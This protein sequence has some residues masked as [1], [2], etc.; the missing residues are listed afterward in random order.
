[1]ALTNTDTWSPS[2]NPASLTES[3]AMTKVISSLPM[4]AVTWDMISPNLISVTVPRYLFLTPAFTLSPPKYFYLFTANLYMDGS[5]LLFRSVA[6]SFPPLLFSHR[7][8]SIGSRLEAL[9]AGSSPKKCRDH[10]PTSGLRAAR[11]LAV[12]LRSY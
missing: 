12:R 2:L 4:R 11:T 6:L 1:M 9:L 3:V 7:K 8:A 5:L 10:Q